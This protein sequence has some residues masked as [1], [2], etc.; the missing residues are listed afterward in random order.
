SASVAAA[1]GGVLVVLAAACSTQ[2]TQV[3][4]PPA[5]T[6]PWIAPYYYLAAGGPSPA[7]IM[8]TTGVRRLTLAFVV[9]DGT[10]QPVWHNGDP[11]P[12][13]SEEAAIQGIRS[14]GGEAAVSFGGMG[15]TKL[16]LTCTSPQALAGVYQTVIS[17]YRLHSIDVD[18]E[19]TEI[20]SAAARQ[21]I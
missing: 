2:G 7:E 1:L 5:A 14:A 8:K 9:S 10:C 13:A 11:L 3:N 15:G 18:I 20:G 21:R 17:T 4:P 12:G 6:G 19:D 16:G